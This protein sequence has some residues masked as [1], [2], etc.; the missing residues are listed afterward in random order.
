MM[1]GDV[2]AVE[3]EP[4]LQ[5]DQIETVRVEIAQRRAGSI[6]MVE[7]AERQAHLM[8]PKLPTL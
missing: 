1:L 2:I 4:V 7:Y 6:E 5:L 3:A 8:I